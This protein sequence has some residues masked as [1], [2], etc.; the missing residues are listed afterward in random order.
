MAGMEADCKSHERTCKAAV[1]AVKRGIPLYRVA[2]RYGLTQLALRAMCFRARVPRASDADMVYIYG[3]VC[4]LSDQIVY[5]GAAKN[6]WRRFAQHLAR[7]VSAAMAGWLSELE[8]GHHKP[9]LLILSR[10]F[11]HDQADIE[12]AWILKLAKRGCPLMN[13][14]ASE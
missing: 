4:P 13:K 7:P 12:R 9:Q 3:L 6:P 10:T 2:K 5:V 8:N 1:S 14:E 11:S